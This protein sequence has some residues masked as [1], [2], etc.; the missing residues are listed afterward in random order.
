VEG[1]ITTLIAPFKQ[2]TKTEIK[3]LIAAR[4]FKFVQF[5]EKLH[6]GDDV[7]IFKSR[8]VNEVKGKIDVLYEK[9]QLMIQAYSDASKQEILT[10][11]PTIQ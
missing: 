3:S 6:G 10:Q 7:H 2:S 8:L 1:Y 11:S 9:S 4:V 5:D